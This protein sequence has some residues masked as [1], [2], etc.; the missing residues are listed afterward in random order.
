MIIIAFSTHTSK[1]I[2]R[3]VCGRFKHVAVIIPMPDA[4]RQMVM[5]QF[6]RPGQIADIALSPRDLRVLGRG[7][8]R[9]VYVT[10]ATARNISGRGCMTCVAYAKRAIGLRHALIQTPDALYKHLNR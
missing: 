10:G 5:K 8:W 3:L 4:S 9:F 7:G 1:I 6:I 2:P